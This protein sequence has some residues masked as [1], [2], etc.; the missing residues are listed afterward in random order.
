MKIVI[1]KTTFTINQ[2]DLFV[3]SNKISKIDKQ[4]YQGSS[5]YRGMEIK[6]NLDIEKEGSSKKVVDKF[7]KGE[8]KPENKNQHLLVNLWHIHKRIES[9][10]EI[11]VSNLRALHDMMWFNIESKSKMNFK[12]Y[13]WRKEAGTISSGQKNFNTLNAKYLDKTMNNLFEFINSEKL[14]DS[15]IIK[16]IIIMFWFVYAHPFYD[17]NGKT[18][19]ILAIWFLNN[20]DYYLSS[21]QFSL[22]FKC[23]RSKFFDDLK[24]LRLD[25]MKGIHSFDITDMIAKWSTW[26]LR[27]VISYCDYALITFDNGISFN[28]TKATLYSAL[29]ISSKFKKQSAFTQKDIEKITNLGYDQK[30][31]N[32][33]LT[34][35]S[36]EGYLI[37]TKK[38]K[39][40]VYSI[41]KL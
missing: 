14:N 9:T 41:I 4:L 25:E 13:P 30:Y 31:L 15:I 40:P 6:N 12:E 34:K 19:R 38:S 39:S 7:I 17:Y 2:K 20:N 29:A 26:L 28:D 24:K 1:G 23:M 33:I 18:S 27:G 37:K 21:M 11:T 3:D 22:V 8:L 5:F 36:Q 10:S 35:M 32:K 16:S